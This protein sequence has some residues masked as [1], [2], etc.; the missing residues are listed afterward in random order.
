MAEDDQGSQGSRRA[1]TGASFC[2]ATASSSSSSRP[3]SHVI[4]SSAGFYHQPYPS[5]SLNT[6]DSQGRSPSRSP[7]RTSP[8]CSPHRSPRH[9]TDA[10]ANFFSE[11][12]LSQLFDVDSWIEEDSLNGLEGE[13]N[14]REPP[15]EPAP[16][17]SYCPPSPP[18]SHY[19]AIARQLNPYHNPDVH[20][21]TLFANPELY[22]ELSP[23]DG[24]EP[25]F[26][27]EFNNADLS[28]LSA[29]SSGSSR[30]SSAMYGKTRDDG[31]RKPSCPDDG[32]DECD[33][34]GDMTPT[35]CS[36]NRKANHPSDGGASSG[37]YAERKSNSGGVS[38]PSLLSELGQ[39]LEDEVWVAEEE[40]ATKVDWQDRCL[41]LE[42]SLQ[43]FRDH[44]GKIR[45]MLHEKVSS[46]MFFFVYFSMIFCFSSNN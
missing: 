20:Y 44:A 7:R 30:F 41:E 23:S 4:T 17:A 36:P 38:L 13:D 45:S 43:K 27:G 42:M 6:S 2:P 21:P 35:P 8:N 22:P 37:S 29:L 18:T 40:Q 11:R 39:Q 5:S 31:G 34:P 32:S 1:S 9:L 15:P 26:S 28:R 3:Y 24:S 25:R 46:I 14:G 12:R 19:A 10:S 16:R 33:G